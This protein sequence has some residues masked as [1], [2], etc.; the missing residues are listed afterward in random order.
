MNPT[1]IELL[2]KKWN[3]HFEDPIKGEWVGKVPREK[4]MQRLWGVMDLRH[5]V[6]LTGVRRSGKSTLMQQ[7]IGKL[8]DKG[9]KPT[10]V[11]YLYFEDLLVQK[12]LLK[13]A[14]IL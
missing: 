7:L 11:L 3:P 10:N 9:T 14:E 1:E 12:Y 6:I 8:I 13:G 5:I 2:I 4:Y